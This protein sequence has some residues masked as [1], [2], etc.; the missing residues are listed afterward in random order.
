M[1]NAP[2]LRVEQGRVRGPAGSR[3]GQ[4][5]LEYGSVELAIQFSDS[6][7]WEHVSVH[8]L[9]ESRCPTWDEMCWV[10]EVFWQNEEAVIQLHPAK[11]Q[12]VN[13]HPYVLHLWRPLSGS[14]PLP[15]L[16]KV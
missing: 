6:E 10:K 3:N 12:Y 13:V 14:I 5:I 4:A 2:I 11:S 16:E 1:R 8:V 9:D 15:E 7:G